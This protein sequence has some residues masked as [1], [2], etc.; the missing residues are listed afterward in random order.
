MHIYQSPFYVYKLVCVKTN[1]F[2]FG[3]RYAHSKQARLPKDDLFHYYYSS[4]RAIH[5]LINLFGKESFSYEVIFESFDR[6][7]TFWFEQQCIQNY[8]HDPNIINEYFVDKNKNGRVFGMNQENLD[9]MTEAVNNL[10]AVGKHNFIGGEVQRT[11]QLRLLAQGKHTSQ[12]PKWLENHRQK[13]RSIETRERKRNSLTKYWSQDTE[14]VKNRK[15]Y[16]KSAE[17]IARLRANNTAYYA[18]HPD[19]RSIKSMHTPEANRKRKQTHKYKN[20]VHGTKP[21]FI[22]ENT[23]QVFCNLKHVS[24]VMD[25]SPS[26]VGLILRGRYKEMKG[27]RFRYLTLEEVD[28]YL[29]SEEYH[30][31][32]QLYRSPS[33]DQN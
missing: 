22:C 2:Y 12:D 29:N 20:R 23:G 9:R 27:Y 6:D 16:L 1:Q 5:D 13:Q 19:L 7:E 26:A 21:W 28:S 11:A 24:E 25:I 17:H 30:N 15:E 3:S 4:S 32:V 14:E 31:L 8:F 10:V 33:S 18:K